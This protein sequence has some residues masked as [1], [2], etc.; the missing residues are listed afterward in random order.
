MPTAQ[1]W[2]VK[3]TAVDASRRWGL[4]CLV[5]LVLFSAC[6]WGLEVSGLDQAAAIAFASALLA[7]VLAIGSPWAGRDRALTSDPLGD[8]RRS[9]TGHYREWH[10]RFLILEARSPSLDER[11]NLMR[12]VE[13][14]LRSDFVLVASRE[15][16]APILVTFGELAN[17]ARELATTHGAGG[18]AFSTLS[19]GCRKVL[20]GVRV[21]LDEPWT[22]DIEKPRKPRG[23]RVIGATAIGALLVASVI[24]GVHFSGAKVRKQLGGEFA[25]LSSE[26]LTSIA[27]SAD[28]HYL[29]AGDASGHIYLR[30]LATRQIVASPVDPAS[31]G[32]RAVAFNPDGQYAVADA[33]GHIY[34]YGHTIVATFKDPGVTSIAFSADSHYLAAGNASGR[35]EL[36]RVN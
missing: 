25:Q 36:Y 1:A 16:E 31:K 9:L 6:W 14:E 18:K 30:D 19:N 12:E 11:R 33:N 32:I 24:V 22:A 4:V 17:N 29:L 21:V 7:V 23:P 2:R 20:E 5:A 27:F 28:S 13:T 26:R 15:S 34:L 10:D 35:V 8:V 3:N